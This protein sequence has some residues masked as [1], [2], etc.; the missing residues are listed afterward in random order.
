[1]ALVPLI[2]GVC[3]V[4]GTFEMTSKPTNAAST[5]I[6]SSVSRST[7]T[8]SNLPH[9]GDEPPGE[10]PP[11]HASALRESCGDDLSLTHHAGP[12][13]DLVVEVEAQF[14]QCQDVARVQRGCVLGHLRRQVQQADDLHAALGHE[15]LARSREL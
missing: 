5:R 1:M 9:R 7:R 15:D 2:S 14:Q 4:F 10:S 6:A 12:G 3:S 13:D 8:A 11:E